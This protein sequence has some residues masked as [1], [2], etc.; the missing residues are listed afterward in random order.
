MIDQASEFASIS[1]A[2]ACRG[3]PSTNANGSATCLW[4]GDA[5][6]YSA[7]VRLAR[8]RRF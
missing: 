2:V 7:R 8:M 4:Q 6:S 1:L 5:A 3:D